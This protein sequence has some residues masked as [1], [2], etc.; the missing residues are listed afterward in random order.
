ML[1]VLRAMR[2]RVMCL[3]VAGP[4][5]RLVGLVVMTFFFFAAGAVSYVISCRLV[6]GAVAGPRPILAGILAAADPHRGIFTVN[7]YLFLADLY[8]PSRTYPYMRAFL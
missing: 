1:C 8:A 6:P 7:L 4:S 2:N 3:A 5:A